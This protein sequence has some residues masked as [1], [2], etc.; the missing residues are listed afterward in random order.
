LRALHKAVSEFLTALERAQ[1]TEDPY[2]HSFNILGRNMLLRPR[3]IEQGG[4]A[5]L[6]TFVNRELHVDAEF[7]DNVRRYLAEH[8]GDDL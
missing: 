4:D 6:K 7:L 5:A 2:M 8:F 1:V 3:A